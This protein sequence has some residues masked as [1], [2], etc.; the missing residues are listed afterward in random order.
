MVDMMRRGKKVPQEGEREYLILAAHMLGH[1]GE[2]AVLRKIESENFWWPYMMRDIRE[3]L[4]GCNLCLKHN[5]YKRGYH[6]PGSIHASRPGDHS[7]VDVVHMPD[8]DTGYKYLLVWVDVFTGFVL[9]RPLKSIT[10]EEVGA[11]LW[12]WFCIFGP[13][14]VITSDNGPEFKNEVIA[15]L[16]KI[17]GVHHRF[18]TPYHP[19][20]NS[21]VENANKSIALVLVKMMMGDP[22]HWQM[23]C[24]LAALMYNIKVGEVTKSSPFSLMFNRRVNEM[25]NYTGTQVE[26][27]TEENWKKHQEAVIALVFPAIEDMQLKMTARTK[28]KFMEKKHN[29]LTADLPNGMEVYI[30][31]PKYTKGAPRPR[32]EQHNI[33]PWTIVRR[34]YNG[35]YLLQDATGAFRTVPIDQM[36]FTRSNRRVAHIKRADDDDDLQSYEVEKLVDHRYND[37]GTL[38]YEVKWK[39]YPTSENTW[40]PINHINNT[41]L[42]KTYNRRQRE[43]VLKQS[44]TETGADASLPNKKKRGAK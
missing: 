28:K 38:E 1:H 34:L 3:V 44:V 16:M 9:C 4:D 15:A 43:A 19:E 30:R 35:P 11:V 40:E 27:I 33:G 8:S 41:S 17:A 14:K 32:Q 24:P 12:E 42:I 5:I 22:R 29:I 10:A 7:Q 6:P 25:I 37:N 2:K 26:P 23:Y 31:D 13:S 18:T 36:I 20:G 39:G 21:R